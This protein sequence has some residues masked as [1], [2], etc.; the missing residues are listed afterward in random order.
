[1][2]ALRGAFKSKLVWLGVLQEVWALVQLY[3]GG[4]ELTTEVLTTAVV[5]ALTIFFRAVT[6]KPLSEK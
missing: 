1:M 5:G 3:L 4:G 6:T 2:D